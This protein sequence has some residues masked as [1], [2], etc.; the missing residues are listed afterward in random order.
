M[1]SLFLVQWLRDLSGTNASTAR[2]REGCQWADDDATIP[3]GA[4]NSP[5]VDLRVYGH[6]VRGNAVQTGLLRKL[7]SLA[8]RYLWAIR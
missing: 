6:G 5:R 8:D 1:L 2:A 3:R 7:E 4:R